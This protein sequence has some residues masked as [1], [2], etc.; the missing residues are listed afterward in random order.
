MSSQPIP[1]SPPDITQAELDAV[2]QV[3]R[4]GWLTT[5]PRT[6][7]FE[8]ALARFC[9]TPRAVCLS[10]ATA[11]L[12]LTLR[13]L[14]I[15]P[16]DEVLVPVYTYT[17]TA[18]AVLHVGAVPV[19][20]DCRPDSWELDWEAVPGAVTPRTKAVIPVDVGGIPCHYGAIFAALEERRGLFR[21]AGA[22]QRLLGRPA[23]VADAAHSLG[24]GI[25]PVESGALADF[26]VFSFHAV[27][28]LTTGE[29]GAVT[30][31]DRPGLDHDALQ[32]RL[33]L[34]SLHGQDRDAL[35]KTRAGGWEYDV[36][37]PGYKCNMTD[38]QAALGLAQ[39]RRYG[40]MLARRRA[41]AA[42]YDQ[43]L[44]GSGVETPPHLGQG[45]RRSSCHLYLTRLPCA[46][47]RDEVAA[48]LARQGIGVNV[49]Y[50]PLPLLT[51][52]RRLGWRAQ[53][54]PNACARYAGALT[55]PL[56]SAMT[57]DQ[58]RRVCIALRALL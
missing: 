23:V 32:R 22:L 14:D 33:R 18:A 52:Y 57:E 12:E 43:L 49:H 58:V 40:D 25:G 17:A 48:G 28:N 19:P 7:E 50:K 3:L 46:H 6:R 8:G 42:L 24:A 37:V 51:A 21:P 13:L 47:R 55:L 4:S 9:G 29:G 5:G 11:G 26:T 15:G 2:A 36:T 31:R 39:L 35:E 10:S 1:F 56:F 27:K 53:A 41:L 45:E 30:W 38:L 54:F 20:L 44:A 34:L 16:G